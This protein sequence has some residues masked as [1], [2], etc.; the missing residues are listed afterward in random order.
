MFIQIPWEFEEPPLIYGEHFAAAM[1][2]TVG[3]QKFSGS[4]CKNPSRF[5]NLSNLLASGIFLALLN[6]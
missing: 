3:S 1:E 5:H 2:S 4:G 6:F